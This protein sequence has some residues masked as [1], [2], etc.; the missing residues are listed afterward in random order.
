MKNLCRELQHKLDN[1][2]RVPQ[3]RP[4]LTFLYFHQ[5]PHHIELVP[6]HLR[7]VAVLLPHHLRIVADPH[8][9]RIVAASHKMVVLRVSVSYFAV[10]HHSS[11]KLAKLQE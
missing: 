6:R 8:H 7:I 2:L 10:L 11:S 5:R 3:E 4:F 1:L 9:L